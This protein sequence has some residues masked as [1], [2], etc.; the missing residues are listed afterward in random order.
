MEPKLRLFAKQDIPVVESYIKAGEE[1]RIGKIFSD[2][3]KFM[4]I[5]K[6][7]NLHKWVD[8]KDYSSFIEDKL[9]DSN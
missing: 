6:N 3:S 8:M 5:C 7:D 4:V 9:V 1:V 2:G